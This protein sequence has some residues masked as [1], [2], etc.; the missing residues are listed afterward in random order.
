VLKTFEKDVI[1]KVK[2]EGYD[3]REANVGDVVDEPSQW[4]ISGAL[5]YS[6]TIITTIGYGNIAP[7][8]A[9]GQIATMVYATFGM[10]IF[11][12]WASNMGTLMA[13]TFTFLY[14]NVCCFVCRRGKKKKALKAIKRQ[15]DRDREA[16]SGSERES[17]KLLWS[18][19]DVSPALTTSTKLDGMT[20]YMQ[21]GLNGS[22][23]L[24]QNS[25][26][27]YNSP[28]STLKMDPKVK[29][30]LSAC[31]TYNLDQGDDDDPLSEAVVE[32]LRHADA[33]DI[34]NERSLNVSP[35]TSPQ[36]SRV[37][38]LD[39]EGSSY[40]NNTDTPEREPSTRPTTRLDIKSPIQTLD[41]KGKL[42][43]PSVVAINKKDGSAN[44]ALL[45]TPPN[46]HSSRISPIMAPKASRD[47]SP[48][49]SRVFLPT[50]DKDEE[51]Y[52]KQTIRSKPS[53][54]D[55]GPAPIE[56][57]PP[58]P[59][60]AFLGFYLTLGAVIFSEW[61]DWTFLEGFYFSFITLT[62]IGFGDYVPGDSVM[63]VDSTDGQY[64][65]LCSVVYV[66][67][68]LAVLSMSFNLIQEEVV[69][70]AIQLAKDCGVIDDD[71]DEDDLDGS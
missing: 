6:V 8:T 63:N 14:A 4:S 44:T 69:D 38:R 65:L 54:A 60:L 67:L 12:L 42:T 47:P 34:I 19:R 62:T 18:E 22:D 7:K 9:W 36:Q 57:V 37:I 23:N 21:R 51:S 43:H 66:L 40:E 20:P 39:R 56:R 52:T 31:A 3:G 59:V 50:S 48:T 27:P 17:S 29:E 30:M 53:E 26:N 2:N 5:L 46:Q 33:M 45:L 15:E 1:L 28:N 64:K 11:M 68:G 70:F 32:E 25:L 13:Q 71:D 49:S 61:E 10:P 41:R 16:R 24:I 58:L 55:V 35:L